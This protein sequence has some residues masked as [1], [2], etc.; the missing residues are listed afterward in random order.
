MNMPSPLLCVR[1]DGWRSDRR[2]GLVYSGERLARGVD[3]RTQ[4][5]FAT[6]LRMY[7]VR[8]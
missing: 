7:G 3:C 4:D 5:D 6:L 8:A 1:I 2:T